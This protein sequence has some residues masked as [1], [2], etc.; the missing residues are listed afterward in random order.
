MTLPDAYNHLFQCHSVVLQNIKCKSKCKIKINFFTFL[1]KVVIELY[2]KE[3][4][5]FSVNHNCD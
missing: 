5:F 2:F 3:L 4:S 1:L